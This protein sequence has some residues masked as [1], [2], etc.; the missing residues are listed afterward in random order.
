MGSCEDV[1]RL[2]LE[3]HSNR[4]RGNGHRLKHGNLN[5]RKETALLWYRLPR[6]MVECPVLETVK[7]LGGT[8]LIN[9]F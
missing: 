9:L 5:I 8:T 4:R 6:E 7:T 2:L 1:A 3:V